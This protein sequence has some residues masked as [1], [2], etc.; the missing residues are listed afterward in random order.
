M[1]GTGERTRLCLLSGL[2]GP[3]PPGAKAH[4]HQDLCA[5]P[6]LQAQRQPKVRVRGGARAGFG[7]SVPARHQPMSPLCA[8]R[9]PRGDAKKCR[10]VYG[11]DH[12]HLWCTACRWKKACQRFLD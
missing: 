9:K 2:P 6:A 1:L 12:R 5:N 4:R 11:M 10:K 7:Q 8:P 3:H